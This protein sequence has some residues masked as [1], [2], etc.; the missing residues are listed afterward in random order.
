[1]RI[2]IRL[3]NNLHF[4]QMRDRVKFDPKTEPFNRSNIIHYRCRIATYSDLDDFSVRLGQLHVG[5]D[6]ALGRGGLDFPFLRRQQ[7]VTAL[8]QLGRLRLVLVHLWM[9]HR[10]VFN[11]E[12]TS[13]SRRSFSLECYTDMEIMYERS[14]WRNVLEKL[15]QAH[16]RDCT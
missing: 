12:A 15:Y 7:V 14:R 9:K 1:M 3:T 11:E 5:H 4:R 6:I 13:S 2:I 10:K 8:Q 16:T